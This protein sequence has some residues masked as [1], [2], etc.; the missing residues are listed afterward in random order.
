MNFELKYFQLKILTFT[1]CVCA[2]VYAN[3]N[4]STIP[5]IRICL[6]FLIISKSCNFAYY[7]IQSVFGIV[8]MVWSVEK[9]KDMKSLELFN[10]TLYICWVFFFFFG[11]LFS[12]RSSLSFTK[13]FSVD[14]CW[15]TNFLFRWFV[16]VMLLSLPLNHKTIYDS[17]I[18]RE[19]ERERER[20]EEPELFS[21]EQFH[22]IK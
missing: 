1:V 13:M 6:R 9:P 10:R 20:D 19:I 17:G 14:N 5:F 3:L 12:F 16:I 7:L 21:L 22:A 15:N 8:N 11:I 18:G 4:F 2:C